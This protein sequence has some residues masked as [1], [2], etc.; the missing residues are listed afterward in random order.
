AV[1][2]S[3]VAAL[4][5]GVLKAMLLN[6]LKPALAVLAVVAMVGLIGYGIAPGQQKGDPVAAQKQA[7]E[8]AEDAVVKDKAEK[9][10][11]TAW[12]KEVDGVQAGLLAEAATC[13]P[14]DKLKFTV[15]LR[16]VGKAEVSVT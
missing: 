16:N 8:K 15:K 12:G 5:E 13:R 6:K 9:K 1:I 4:A 11:T 14:G 3:K 2:S 10:D 7:S